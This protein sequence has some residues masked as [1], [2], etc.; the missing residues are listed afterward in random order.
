M[1]I[2]FSI[3]EGFKVIGARHQV[4]RTVRKSWRCWRGRE[5]GLMKK[6]CL[7]MRGRGGMN[8]NCEDGKRV[9]AK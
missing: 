9:L 3:S 8:S 7:W 2:T 1:L 5:W 6:G 4:G